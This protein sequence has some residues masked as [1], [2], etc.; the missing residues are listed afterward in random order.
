[1]ELRRIGF[2]MVLVIALCAMATGSAE[3]RSPMISD[4]GITQISKQVAMRRWRKALVVDMKDCSEATEELKSKL[5]NRRHKALECMR[6][7]HWM[8]GGFD[9]SQRFLS[10]FSPAKNHSSQLDR[11][12]LIAIVATAVATFCFVASL[13]CCCFLLRGGNDEENS[14]YERR[15]DRPLLNLADLSTAGSSSQ[16]SISFGNSN[17]KRISLNGR[18]PTSFKSNLSVECGNNECSLDEA[19]S[20]TPGQLL[21][22]LKPPPGRQAP[23]PPKPP[24]PPPLGPRPPPPPPK[25]VRAPPAPPPKGKIK[26]SP[27]GP[28]RRGHSSSDESYDLDVGSGN[29]KTKL[30]P[31]FW[32]KVMANPDHSMVWH[33]ISA[34][35]FQFNEEMMESLFGYNAIDNNK[36]ERKRDP[37]EP[38]T[39]YIRIIDMRKAQNLSILL[40]ALNI[41]T[42][43]VIGSLREG[44]ELPVELLQTLLKMAPTPDEELKLRLFTGDVSQLGPAE[45]FLKILVEI[46][47]AFKRIESLIFM[48]SLQEEVSSIK[49]SFVTLEVS[50]NKLRSNR[51]FLKLLE[52]VLK[53]GNRMN[54]GTYRGGAQAF[55]LDTLLKLSDVKGTDGKTTLLHFVVLEIIRSEGIRA[56]RTARMSGSVSSVMSEDTS[57]DSNQASGEHYRNLGLQ[58]VSGLSSE[59]EDVK[60]AAIL[61]A[62]VLTSS[63]S[64]LRQSLTKTKA[65]I[66]SDMKNLEEDGEFYNSLLSFIDRAESD[67]MWLSEEEKRIMALVKGTADYFHGQAGREEGLRLFTIVRDFLVMLDKVCKEVREQR[68]AKPSK[69]F[70]QEAPASSATSKENNQSDLHLQQLF[71]STAGRRID[72]SSSDEESSSP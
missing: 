45:R 57:D 42:E 55:K 24:P 16:S 53:T 47:F 66:E 36:N 11:R 5:W 46:P 48:I 21:P 40:R 30:K 38:S 49:D 12:T 61:D 32:D 3:E 1:M 68:A 71:P 23:S 62:D 56:A 51:L 14:E 52:A 35:S 41:T 69:A 19:S 54:D 4:N 31:F 26:P 15:D 50:S 63:V 17:S 72:H 27:L 8:W 18:K 20:T 9:N 7:R 37:S 43:E 59:L 60:K 64:K 29:Q 65:F 28:N 70:R 39:Q 33:E 67:V 22:P 44:N 25:V 58:V 2:E 6:E 10:D 13:F 34:G